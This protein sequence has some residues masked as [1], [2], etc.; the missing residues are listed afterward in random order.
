MLD[1]RQQ[2]LLRGKE[3]SKSL[4]IEILEIPSFGDPRTIANPFGVYDILREN[5]PVYRNEELGLVMVT[6]YDDVVSVL[7][8]SDTFSS[9]YFATADFRGKPPQSGGRYPG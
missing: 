6:R 1:R 2:H 9:S 5:A 4:D 7:H 8:D 3:M